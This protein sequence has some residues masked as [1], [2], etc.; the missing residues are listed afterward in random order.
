MRLRPAGPS[1]VTCPTVAFFSAL[2]QPPKDRRALGLAPLNRWPDVRWPAVCL[3]LKQISGGQAHADRN[4]R[5]TIN[6]TTL[7]DGEESAGVACSLKEKLAI[8]H[9]LD[10]LQ[11]EGHHLADPDQ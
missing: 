9:G 6:D 8:A 11:D 3:V 7:R 1:P 5:I 10:A 4:V 2:S